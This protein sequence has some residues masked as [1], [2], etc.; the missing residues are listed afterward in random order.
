MIPEPP[1]GVKYVAFL[2]VLGF[3][4][5]VEYADQNPEGRSIIHSVIKTLRQTLA[6]WPTGDFVFT[7]FSDCI[8]LSGGHSS[9]GLNAVLWGS[10][11][12]ANNLLSR[13]VLLRGGITRGNITHT[14]DV[15][16]GPAMIAAYRMDRTGSPPRISIAQN[17]ID[18]LSLYSNGEALRQFFR[19][20]DYDLTHM[21]HILYEYESYDQTP[22]VGKAVLDEP[23]SGIAR[24]IAFYASNSNYP[25]DVRAKWRWMRAYWNDAVSKRG[26]LQ[27]A[28]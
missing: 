5:Q 3:S 2:D 18:D 22:Q 13:G 28:E 24:T 16:F 7:Q 17:V 10:S 9:A 15:L 4:A 11:L 14:D 21:L 8:V 19:Q 1:Y 12:L 6:K 25:P 26:I 27:R 20:D 23:A